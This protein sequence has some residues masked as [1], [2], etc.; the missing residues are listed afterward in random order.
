MIQKIGYAQNQ[1]G[2]GSENLAPPNESVRL[3]D[4]S[5]V[6]SMFSLGARDTDSPKNWEIFNSSIPERAIP[7]LCAT[8][9]STCYITILCVSNSL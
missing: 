9:F 5:I 1:S 8:I 7:S 4:N 3:E 2:N 6:S